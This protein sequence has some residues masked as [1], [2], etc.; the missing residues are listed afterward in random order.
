MTPDQTV[1][2]F[3]FI[4]DISI[5][6]NDPHGKKQSANFTVIF[7]SGV[8]IQVGWNGGLMNVIAAVPPDFKVKYRF[9]KYG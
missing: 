9:F 4:T 7:K 2:I 1:N 3:S 5:V 6:N 8:G